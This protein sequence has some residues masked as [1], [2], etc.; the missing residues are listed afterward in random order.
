MIEVSGEE[1]FN[2][3]NADGILNKIRVEHIHRI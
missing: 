2:E 3:S 1:N